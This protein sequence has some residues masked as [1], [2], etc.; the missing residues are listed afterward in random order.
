[1]EQIVTSTN[2]INA[3]MIKGFLESRGIHA[4]FGPAGNAG[5]GLGS[6]AAGQDQHVL[7]EPKN[8]EEAL[9]LLREEGLIS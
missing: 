7:V 2:E 6:A 3:A 1:M 4:T 9:K 5:V 8:K